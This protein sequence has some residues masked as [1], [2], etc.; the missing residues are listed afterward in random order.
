[1]MANNDYVCN[2]FL[3]A[4]RI[5]ARVGND[6]ST[7]Q[8]E[9]GSIVKQAFDTVKREHITVDNFILYLRTIFIEYEERHRKFYEQLY[10]QISEDETMENAWYR[11][12][13]QWSYLD[14]TLL[15]HIIHKCQDR[16]L[17]AKMSNYKA[18]AREFRCRTRLYDFARFYTPFSRTY[19]RLLQNGFVKATLGISWEECHLENL[20]ILKTYITQ[21][22]FL[23]SFSF[24]LKDIQPHD[25]MRYMVVRWAIHPLL[26]EWLEQKMEEIDVQHFLGIRDILQ[27]C[28]GTH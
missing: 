28:Y 19:S 22:Y 8:E 18:T 23:P 15:D 24:V 14:Y 25:E 4:V 13:G 10:S 16:E 20:M 12:S 5:K 3:V 2:Y 26:C 7:L 1:M 9:F 21:D 11:L 6:I 17:K 27:F